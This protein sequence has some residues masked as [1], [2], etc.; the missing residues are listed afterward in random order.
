MKKEI[1]LSLLKLENILDK[2]KG[3]LYVDD[4]KNEVKKA[5][6]FCYSK[7]TD[8][9]DFIITSVESK[10]LNSINSEALKSGA[11][12]SEEDVI[13][14]ISVI[15]NEIF[16]TV[17]TNE[18]YRNQFF[19]Y[20][21]HGDAE[22]FIEINGFYSEENYGILEIKA[23]AKLNCTIRT[24]FEFEVEIYDK[25][26]KD[27]DFQEELDSLKLS[28]N[29]RVFY[30]EK[31]SEYTRFYNKNIESINYYIGNYIEESLTNL[32]YSKKDDIENSCKNLDKIVTY[33]DINRVFME[34]DLI[35]PVIGLISVNFSPNHIFVQYLNSRIFSATKETKYELSIG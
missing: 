27:S 33:E 20:Y 10:V 35:R 22:F 6:S 11:V 1:K 2:G 31:F 3:D 26:K 9:R 14:K 18:S 28:K 30:N 32:F 34:S 17:K 15:F 19:D 24:I 13:S 12:L 16:S 4:I 8:G 21:F 5:I 29:E 25:V 7:I 23:Y